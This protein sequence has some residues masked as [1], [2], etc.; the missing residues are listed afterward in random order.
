MRAKNTGFSICVAIGLL[1][2]QASKAWA[3]TAPA[4][5]TT[6]GW[7]LHPKLLH[8]VHREND[9]AA[10][11]LLSSLP[12]DGRAYALAA[13]N[14]G[15]ALL[16]LW[17]LRRSPDDRPG[18]ALWLGCFVAGS[19]GNGIDRIAQ[20]SVTDFIRLHCDYE[21]VYSTLLRFFSR[22]DGPVFNIADVLLIAGVLGVVLADTLHERRLARS[23]PESHHADS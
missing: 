18:R 23:T 12:F 10:F 16:G 17:L 8:L 5:Q 22:A 1:L 3:R 9:A 7:A 2:D 11:S 19:V 21:P 20:G 14:L 15:A 13:L 4:L 6:D